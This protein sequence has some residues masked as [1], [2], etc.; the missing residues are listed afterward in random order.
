MASITITTEILIVLFTLISILCFAWLLWF[1]TREY[2]RIKAD[3]STL[4]DMFSSKI[5]IPTRNYDK[6][7]GICLKI[8]FLLPEEDIHSLLNI[9]KEQEETN[10]VD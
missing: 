4:S 8:S 10:L 1:I 6:L 9:E 2:P 5:N 3:A 7:F